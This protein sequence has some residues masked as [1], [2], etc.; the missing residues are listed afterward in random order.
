MGCTAPTRTTIETVVGNIID[1][2]RETAS[3]S[4]IV[5]L[6]GG[7]A[8]INTSDTGT[9]AITDEGAT[10][11]PY[12]TIGGTSYKVVAVVS[13]TSF[14]VEYSGGLPSGSTWKADAPYFFKGNLIDQSQEIDRTKDFNK[15][16]PAII[17]PEVTRIRYINN[18]LDINEMIASVDLF[19]M[20][21]CNYEDWAIEDF[22]TKVVD[23]MEIMALDFNTKA[24]GY[25]YVGELDDSDATINK[26]SKWGVQVFRNGADGQDTLFNDNLGGVQYS[27]DLPIKR[28]LN[29]ECC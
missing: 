27:I 1:L 10:V 26:I 3:I 8:T 7:Q 21:L 9:I 14:T 20:N 11:N 6:G 29:S 19:F 25:R 12:I 4:S 23:K 13:D 15:K 24:D 28:S 17:L 2:M 16:Y 18:P 22:Y 5:D